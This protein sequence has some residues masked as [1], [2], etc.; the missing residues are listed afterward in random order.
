ML[1][2]GALRRWPAALGLALALLLCAVSGALAATTHPLGPWGYSRRILSPGQAQYIRLTVPDAVVAQSRSDLADLRIVDERGVEIGY[3]VAP[4]SSG[5]TLLFFRSPEHQYGLLYGNPAA[6]APAYGVEIPADAVSEPGTLGP[7]EANPFYGSSPELK[8]LTWPRR[9]PFAFY[10]I[11]GSVL[12]LLF[13]GMYARTVVR[14]RREKRKIE[15]LLTLER[16]SGQ[17]PEP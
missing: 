9:Y 17:R 8:N 16:Q 15:A 6:T 11:A 13:G 4:E 12:I 5:R 10:S 3:V 2:P 1:H 7:Q 14:M